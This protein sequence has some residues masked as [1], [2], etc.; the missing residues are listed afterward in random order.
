MSSKKRQKN[1]ESLLLTDKNI[2]FSE[3]YKNINDNNINV[4]ERSCEI[5]KA[6]V[7]E[8]DIFREEAYGYKYVS[9]ELKNKNNKYIDEINTLKNQLF[10][11]DQQ[12]GGMN[13]DITNIIK[14]YSNGLSDERKREIR[15]KY[16]KFL[17]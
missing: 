10:L 5:I 6:L 11:Y 1:D 9:E 16:K 12:K 2:N 17:D 4:V 15:E 14:N 3:L 8:N 13:T 7:N